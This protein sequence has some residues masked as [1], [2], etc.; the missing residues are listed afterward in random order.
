[1]S[2]HGDNIIMG[3]VSDIENSTIKFIGNGNLLFVE[4]GVKL[5]DSNI[6]FKGSNSLV[7]LSSNRNSYIVKISINN[8]CTVFIG[9]N[10]Y[11]N[12]E[13]LIVASESKNVII[14]NDCL[15][16]LGVTFRNADAHLIYNLDTGER[17]NH[18]K[19]IY[20]GDHVWI[21]Q[22][23]LLLKGAIV[24]SG[25]IIGASSVI[26]NKKIMSNSIWAGNPVRKI[27][28]N[29]FWSGECV[30]SW[31]RDKTYNNLFKKNLASFRDDSETINID[32]F[33][34]NLNSLTNVHQ[35]LEFLKDTYI[36]K[37]NRMFVS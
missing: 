17:L 10:N 24:G 1:M 36:G 11:F 33:E 13:T 25:S 18:T 3:N 20:I 34:R 15:L 31:D 7:Y 8:A 30:H 14:G 2:I 6:T 22:N 16:S 9:S 27:K 19:S 23:A 37:K 21:G 12:E 28:E 5:L 4:D 26:S 29:I 35:K 32:D